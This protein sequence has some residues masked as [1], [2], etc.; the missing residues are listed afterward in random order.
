MIVTVKVKKLSATAR[1]PSRAYEYDACVDLYADETVVIPPN[2][3]ARV[4][5]GLA[6]RIPEG[7][8]GKIF[9]RSGIAAREDASGLHVGGGVIDSGYRGDVKVILYFISDSPRPFVVLPGM[10]IAQ[11]AI[12]PVPETRWI[13]A[14]RE[15]DFSLTERGDKGFGSS[16][17]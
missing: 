10:K 1:F 12:L 15:E 5:T 13:L 9:G 11:L 3:C 14:E 16:G 17:S 8:F 2:T 7:Y 4:S 6:L